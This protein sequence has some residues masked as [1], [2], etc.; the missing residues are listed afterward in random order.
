MAGQLRVHEDGR[1]AVRFERR[2][3]H[4]AAKVWRALTETGLLREWFVDILDYDRSRLDFTPGA[5]LRFAAE[6]MPDGEGT[7][8]RCDPPRLLEYTWDGETLRWELH[9]DGA[10]CLLVFTNIVGDEDTAV[11]VKAGWAAGLDRLEDVLAADR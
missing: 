8:V 10:G 11:A 1:F 5:A 4:P 6:G 2:L 3:T 9:P 7:V